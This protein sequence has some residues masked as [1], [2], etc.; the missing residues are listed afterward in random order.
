METFLWIIFAL[1]VSKVLLKALAP[2]QNKALNDKIK[3]GYEAIKAYYKYCKQF[4]QNE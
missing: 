4:W 3:K 1:V 2:Y